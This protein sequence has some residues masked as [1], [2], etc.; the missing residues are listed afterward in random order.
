VWL[1]I[2]VQY[3]CWGIVKHQDDGDNTGETKMEEIRI[4]ERGESNWQSWL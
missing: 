3:T 1:G 2:L 4:Q